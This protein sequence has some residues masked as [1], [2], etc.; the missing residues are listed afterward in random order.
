MI[1]AGYVSA[2]TEE[3][4]ERV[5]STLDIRGEL[6]RVK[7]HS[8]DELLLCWEVAVDGSRPISERERF[9]LTRYGKDYADS[10]DE[11]NQRIDDFET[12][13]EGNEGGYVLIQKSPTLVFVGKLASSAIKFDTRLSGF[14]YPYGAMAI[15]LSSVI[16]TVLDERGQMAPELTR[17]FVNRENYFHMI[18]EGTTQQNWLRNENGAAIF[19]VNHLMHVDPQKPCIHEGDEYTVCIGLEEIRKWQRDNLRWAPHVDNM[20]EA[21]HT[22]YINFPV[23]EQK[24]FDSSLDIL[25]L[26]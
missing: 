24:T 21:W 16:W 1:E 5:A 23:A 18:S 20:M 14:G 9:L 4:E 7:A 26:R 25:G 17:D 15:E 8:M 6:Q 22:R 11:Y 13:L 2:W 10:P 3:S 12:R 19:D